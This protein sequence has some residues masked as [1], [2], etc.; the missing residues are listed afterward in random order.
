MGG[1]FLEYVVQ[2]KCGCLLVGGAP[3]TRR[4]LVYSLL[5]LQSLACQPL[6]F[7]WVE[8]F[9]LHPSIT[10]RSK[11]STMS[12]I[13]DDYLMLPLQLPAT[14][15]IGT[16][17]AHYVYLRRHQPRIPTPDDARTLFAANV[18]VDATEASLRTLFSALGGGRVEAVR[19]EDVPSSTAASIATTTAPATAAADRSRNSKKRKRP[20]PG[21][22][23][24][25]ASSETTD[26]KT[27]GRKLLPSGATAL[28]RFVDIESCLA[29]LRCISSRAS[30]SSSSS[31]ALPGAAAEWAGATGMGV[32]RYSQHHK[33]RFPSTAHLQGAVDAFMAA[34]NAEEARQAAAARR[35][36]QQVDEDGFVTV[37]RGSRINADEEAKRLLLE[38]E[39]KKTTSAGM[40][41][42][43]R[44]QVREERKKRHLELIRKFEDDRKIVE[45]RKKGRR[46]VPES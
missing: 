12:K 20:S 10:Q 34:F 36:S 6:F 27:W 24:T 22:S 9:R 11:H 35:R 14:P 29:T 38:K 31:S 7:S 41:G 46:F 8:F 5:L 30:S 23:S 25:T 39:R 42:F 28:V 32:A 21:G 18:P 37:T 15:T 19:F 33:L 44:F 13:K 4:P 43:Y 3:I 17:A 45:E 40:G 1:A 26:I 2:F 16:P